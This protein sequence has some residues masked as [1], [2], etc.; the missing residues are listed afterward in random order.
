MPHRVHRLAMLKIRACLASGSP[1]HRKRIVAK[2]I[3]G[4]ALPK[5]ILETALSSV[6]QLVRA[7]AEPEE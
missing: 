3:R 6:L 7:E 1:I 2:L 4:A 5:H